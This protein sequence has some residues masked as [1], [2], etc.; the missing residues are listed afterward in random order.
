VKYRAD[1]SKQVTS[2]QEGFNSFVVLASSPASTVAPA[3]VPTV[4]FE[5]TTSPGTYC[6]FEGMAGC[7]AGA[8]YEQ[9][10]TNLIRPV[11]CTPIVTLS[12][13]NNQAVATL[14]VQSY[15]PITVTA[16][17]G[18]YSF[19]N[20]GQTYYQLQNIHTLYNISRANVYLATGTYQ[21]AYAVDA[22]MLT[23][24]G[25]NVQT[26][27]YPSNANDQMRLRVRCAS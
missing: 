11:Q 26:T 8:A 4:G 7:F 19:I 2:F 1:L 24:P 22:K 17:S 13:A 27:T 25:D 5:V 21:I 18:Y 10:T 9:S 20:N 12:N 15:A 16:T 14:P 3:S 6:S 23:Q